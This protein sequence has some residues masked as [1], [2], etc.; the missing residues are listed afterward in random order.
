VHVQRESLVQ[1]TSGVHLPG[2]D[3]QDSGSISS[4]SIIDDV[5][6][7]LIGAETRREVF[8]GFADLGISTQR[9]KRTVDRGSILVALRDSPLAGRVSEDRP[10]VTAGGRSTDGLRADIGIWLDALPDH[11]LSFPRQL[12]HELGCPRDILALLTLG[13]GGAQSLQTPVLLVE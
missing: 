9:F 12:L 3:T 6:F 11:L 10:E 7:H 8:S 4:D 13:N 5:L 1:V 2:Q